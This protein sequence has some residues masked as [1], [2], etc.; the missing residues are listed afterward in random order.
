M[1][2][3]L[4]PL[5]RTFMGDAPVSETELG[6]RTGGV[7]LLTVLFLTDPPRAVPVGGL[8]PS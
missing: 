6:G 5:L 8:E 7:R 2:A 4:E 1:T 3:G